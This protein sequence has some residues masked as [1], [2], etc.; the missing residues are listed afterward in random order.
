MKNM[1]KILAFTMAFALTALTAGCGQKA[2]TETS[3]DAQPAKEASSEAASGET[4]TIKIGASP[5]PHA[6]ILESIKPI[7][8]EQ[9]VI[10]EIQEFT[11]YVLPNKALDAGDIDANYFQHLPFLEK[12]NEEN[13]TDLISAAA[14][15]FEPLGVYPGKTADVNAL[16]EK[17]SIAVPNDPTNEARALLLLEKLG[18]ITMKEDAGLESTPL[19]IVENP[20]DID[21]EEVEAAQLPSVLP[22]VD[23]AVI[24]GNYSVS[25]GIQDTV[26]TTED[27]ESEAAQ[28]FANIIAVRAGDEERPEIQKLVAALQSEEVAN[29]ISEKYNGTVIPVF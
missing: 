5:A 18:L 16:P 25:A 13:G 3:S 8:E 24:N 20:K 17:A 6:E 15:H 4:V 19:D 9:G 21:F 26:L 11:D 27:K 10:L 29:F 1:K 22:D 23:V 12:F 14:I 7:L 28:K 2:E